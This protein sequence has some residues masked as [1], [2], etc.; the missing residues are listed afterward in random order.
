M[1]FE[2]LEENHVDK[3]NDS[4][5]IDHGKLK[6]YKPKD[7]FVF[8][9]NLLLKALKGRKKVVVICDNVDELS[10]ALWQAR[11]FL[12]HTIEI[13]DNIEYQKIFITDS[14]I[15]PIDAE[16]IVAYLKASDWATIFIE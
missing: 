13:D 6:I 3:Q 11:G 1:G 14:K 15:N 4:I 9:K 10:K 7:P 16:V 12:P 2:K 8:L 5:F